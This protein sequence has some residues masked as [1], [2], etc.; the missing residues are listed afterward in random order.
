MSGE[1]LADELMRWKIE[2]SIR[3]LKQT[4][5]NR[6]LNTHKVAFGPLVKLFS[7]MIYNASEGFVEINV[8]KIPELKRLT[9]RTKQ[10]KE[11]LD[12]DRHYIVFEHLQEC[13]RYLFVRRRKTRAGKVNLSYMFQHHVNRE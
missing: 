4:F 6:C 7:S 3:Y 1:A 8:E 10:P 11:L 13:H 2:V 9:R 12:V 5:D